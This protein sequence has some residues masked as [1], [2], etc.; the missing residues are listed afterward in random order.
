MGRLNFADP[1]AAAR[2]VL[3]LQ[4]KLFMTDSL[5]QQLHHRRD[6][7]NDGI[8][9]HLRYL[10]KPSSGLRGDH[11]QT[12]R[13]ILACLELRKAGVPWPEAIRR[14]EELFPGARSKQRS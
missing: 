11:Q 7:G 10:A 6:L 4:K 2:D 13:R 3:E 12:A 14:A 1:E 8:E 9:A 5:F